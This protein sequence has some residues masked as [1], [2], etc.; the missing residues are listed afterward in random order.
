MVLSHKKKRQRKKISIWRAKNRIDAK[1]DK[2]G[3]SISGGVHHFLCNDC[4]KIIQK[5]K[6]VTEGL[7][8]R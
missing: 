7:D 2:C 8:R 6:R 3:K 1:C 4:W 5:Q